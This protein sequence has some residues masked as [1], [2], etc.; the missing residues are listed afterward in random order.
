MRVFTKAFI[1]SVVAG[2]ATLAFSPAH[3]QLGEK[4]SVTVSFAD[5][6][7]NSAAGKAR[8]DRRIAFAAA[9]VCGPVDRLS[10]IDRR[11]NDDCQQRAIADAGRAMVEVV[12]NTRTSL[13][14]AAN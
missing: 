13:R 14:V 5:L 4:R 10:L 11:A 3:A 12:A 7:L 8:L 9:T 1:A 2:V 6:N